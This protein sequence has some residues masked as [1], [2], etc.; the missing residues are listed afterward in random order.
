MTLLWFDGF[1]SYENQADFNA[2]KSEI[3][4]TLYSSDNIK[5]KFGAYG[6][7]SSRGLYMDNSYHSIYFEVNSNHTEDTVVLGFAVYKQETGSPGV[8]TGEPFIV[9][10]D[11]Q[12]GGSNHIKVCLNSSYNFQVYRNNTLLG[13][14]SG[15]TLSN[16]TEHFFEMKVK[17]SNTVGTVE[18]WLDG[19]KIL[20]LSNQ[21][22]MEGSNAYIRK[23]QLRPFY[24]DLITYF[25]DLY[26]LDTSGSAPCND[27]LGDIRI[28]VCR[29]NGAG[30]HTDFTPSAGNNY[31][32]V[33]ETYPDDDT[34]YNDGDAVAEQ[35]S[36][37][38]DDLDALGA[39]IF[40]VK[41]QVTCKK[42]DSGARGYKILTRSGGS[43]Y[44][45]SEINPATTFATQAKIYETNPDDSAAWEEADVNGMEVGVE[46]T[47]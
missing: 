8:N 5:N 16:Q 37:A 13:T 9:M 29:P 22:T 40:G 38:L 26:F 10:A 36:Y 3:V 30:S 44:L 11:S 14:T 33:D 19:T 25:D 7:R 47:T 35:D 39:T 1:E 4:D 27:R 46:I 18:V 28:D 12:A 21:D 20:N 41:S 6:R 31:E 32:N 45:S 24:N 17:V 23:V 42:S 2:T 15:K 43:D 34:T